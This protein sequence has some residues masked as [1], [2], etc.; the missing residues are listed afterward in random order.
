MHCLEL[1]VRRYNECAKKIGHGPSYPQE[2]RSGEE[3][4]F[5]RWWPPSGPLH[6]LLPMIIL[7]PY[8]SLFTFDTTHFSLCAFQLFLNMS[9]FLCCTVSSLRAIL[10]IFIVITHLTPPTPHVSSTQWKITSWLNGGL[11]RWMHYHWMC[12]WCGRLVPLEIESAMEVS[13]QKVYLGLLSGNNAWRR[14]GAQHWTGPRE[15][16]SSMLGLEWYFKTIPSWAEK[17]VFSSLGLIVIRCRP[18]Q[19]MGCDHNEAVP[20]SWGLC[21]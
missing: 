11:D 4:V 14:E 5:T 21:R 8:L 12:G 1:S 3:T 7:R 16:L 15:K 17:S 6:E 20:F 2:L 19:E 9:Y 10:D 18:P 13:T